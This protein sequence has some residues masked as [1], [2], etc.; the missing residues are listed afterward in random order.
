MVD[1]YLQRNSYTSRLIEESP[2]PQLGIIVVI[3]AFDEDS[4]IP[5]VESLFSCDSPE[6]KVEIIVV[7]NASEES[8]K[9]VIQRNVKAAKSLS[10]WYENQQNRAI[11]LFVLSFNNLP[12]KQAGVGLARKIG[13]DEALRRFHEINNLEGIIACFDADTKCS[14]NY[15]IAIEE[16]F[17]KNKKGKAASVYF[18]HEIQG[19]N[20]T[21][22][23][24]EAIIYYEAHLRYY[25]NGLAY[26]NLP[27]AYHTIGSSMAVRAKDYAAQ[28]GMNRRKAG[29]DFYFL[30]KYMEV[31]GLFNIHTTKTIP[32]PR[33]SHRVTFGTGR[34]VLQSIQEDK[35][36][37]S[38]YSFD[39]FLY[40]KRTFEKIED[41]YLSTPYGVEKLIGFIGEEKF[42][43]KIEELRKLSKD[44]YD[45]KKRFFVW[46]NAFHILKFIHFLRDNYYMNKSLQ[47]EI[48]LLLKSMG[49]ERPPTNIKELL[50]ILREIDRKEP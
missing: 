13:M 27:Y 34:S 50:T 30:Q 12:R 9:E 42:Q 22:H 10:E 16:G 28:G 32:S 40:L 38:S 5:A 37:R 33:P 44:S 39:I 1:L 26:A 43:K 35:D 31:G 45:F 48:P 47:S 25:K 36:I 17:Q 2:H 21:E 15:L 41:W 24:Y 18:E 23:I 8:S 7:F 11:R 19:E 29:E 14:K 20:F 6:Q 46:M 4:L 49:M 3:P